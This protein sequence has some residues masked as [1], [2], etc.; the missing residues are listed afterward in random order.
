MLLPEAAK[1]QATNLIPDTVV[2][3]KQQQF[4]TVE[5]SRDSLSVRTATLSQYEQQHSSSIG[6]G[7]FESPEIA[8]DFQV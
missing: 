6:D 8:L 2:M 4:V 7:T 3:K 5:Y 1:E